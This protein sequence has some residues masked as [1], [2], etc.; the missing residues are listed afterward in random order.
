ML[1]TTALPGYNYQWTPAANLSS[2]TVAQ[3][4]L[5]G[6][7]TTAAPIIQKYVLRATTT[8]GCFA[9]DPVLI[10]INP[11]PATNSIVGL[12]LVCPTVLYPTI[13]VI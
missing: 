4:V 13:L 8:L 3:L 11:R 12:A 6:T 5:T 1:G 10:N 2:A 7:N 9:K